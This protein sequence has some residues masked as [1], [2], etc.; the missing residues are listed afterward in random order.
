MSNREL[1]ASLLDGFTESQLFNVAA[2]LQAMKQA[3]EDA[4][5]P[6]IPNS[7]TVAALREGDEMLRTGA[8]QHFKGSA[9]E[10]FAMLDAEDDDDA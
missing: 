7:E 4:A 8:G 9:E 1:C 10:F 5:S 2:M 3:I 6:D